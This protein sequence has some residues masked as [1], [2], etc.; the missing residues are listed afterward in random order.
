MS[1]RA[2]ALI[3]ELENEPPARWVE[4]MLALRREDRRQDADALVAEFKR[5]FPTERLPPDLQ[6]NDE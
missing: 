1:A 4:R 6:Q 2:S 3:A 5:R